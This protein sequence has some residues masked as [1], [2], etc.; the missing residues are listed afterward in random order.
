MKN[1]KIMLASALMAGVA[2]GG[3]MILPGQIASATSDSGEQAEIE[4]EESRKRPELSEEK[5]AEIKAKLDAMTD[6]EKAAWKEAHKKGNRDAS[7]REKPAD[8]TD[9]EWEQKKAERKEK[10]KEKFA[11]MTEEE[12]QAWLESHKKK[13]AETSEVT[14]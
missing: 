9:E 2:V 14:E 12:K 10:M 4:V 7:R 13:D 3:T 8:M 5:K 6:E 11:N 1:K